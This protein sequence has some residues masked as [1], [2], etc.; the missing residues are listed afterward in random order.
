MQHLNSRYREGDLE[1]DP[2][3]QGDVDNAPPVKG[4]HELAIAALE[5]ANASHARH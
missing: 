1:N 2:F 5:S 3:S 4:I